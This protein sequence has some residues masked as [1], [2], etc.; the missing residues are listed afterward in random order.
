MIA[1]N[2]NG[3]RL[4]GRITFLFSGIHVASKEACQ[5]RSRYL[6]NKSADGGR[7]GDGRSK[8]YRY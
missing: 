1:R 5:D 6:M 4:E 2:G 7:N 3:L 8:E